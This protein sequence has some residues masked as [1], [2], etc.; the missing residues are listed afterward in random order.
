MKL[1]TSMTA[2][3]ANYIGSRLRCNAGTAMVIE[4]STNADGAL[5]KASR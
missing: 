1:D 2:L 5:S 3:T 4:A